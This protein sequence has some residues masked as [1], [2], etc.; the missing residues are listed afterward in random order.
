VETIPQCSELAP[1]FSESPPFEFAYAVFNEAVIS[2]QVCR[3]KFAINL[4]K[5]VLFSFIS[6]NV[7]VYSWKPCTVI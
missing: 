4:L 5:L 6:G 1:W 7:L 3:M 2:Y